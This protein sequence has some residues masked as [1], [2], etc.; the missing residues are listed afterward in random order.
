MEP[1]RY[2]IDVKIYNVDVLVPEWSQCSQRTRR[3]KL[4]YSEVP[5]DFAQMP[6][7]RHI[8][9]SGEKKDKSWNLNLWSLGLQLDL[10]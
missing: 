3:Y 5:G 1:F 2:I 7:R 9:C 4:H 8:S 10:L 6:L